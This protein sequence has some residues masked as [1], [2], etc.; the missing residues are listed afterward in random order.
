MTRAALLALLLFF[1]AFPGSQPYALAGDPVV[2][3]ALVVDPAP[4]GSSNGN[5]VFDPGETVLFQPAWRNSSGGPITL[6]GSL[7]NFSGPAGPTYTLIDG[8]ANYGTIAPGLASSCAVGGDC[9]GL[10]I[11][12]SRPQAHWDAGA[13]EAVSAG[14]AKQWTIHIGGSFSDAPAAHP[15]YRFVETIFHRGITAGCGPAI[16]CPDS[17]VTRGQMAVFLLVSSFGAAYAPP[18]GTGTIFEDV[19][20]SHPFVSWIEDL[21]SRGT[22][23]GCATNPL[24]YCPENA[25]TREQMAV[26][27]LRTR[28][29][30][31]F[32]PPPATGIFEDVPVSSPF[33][34]WIEALY[35][36]GI[37]AGCS[38]APV[39]YC[40]AG[41]NTRGQMAVFLTST[42]ELKAYG[43]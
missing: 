37:T 5:G 8:T 22:T 3:D 38:S 18:P 36:R 27:L 6:T 13:L 20:L 12:G 40:P 7:S 23:A 9:Y 19:P 33:A 30:T 10:E 24:R 14:I 26:F 11:T 31:A 1:S 15:F 17:P 25:V 29:G 28:L 34:P 43:P 35:A 42:F 2:A 16:Y 21:Y 39:L 4:G 32:T 41:P